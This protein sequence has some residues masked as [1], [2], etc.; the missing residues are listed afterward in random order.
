MTAPVLALEDASFAFG[1]L[2]ILDEESV[3]VERGELVALVGPNGSGKTTV[4]ELLAGLRDPDSGTVRRPA[5]AA[6]STAYLPQSPGFRSGFTVRETLSFYAGLVG[7]GV[8]ADAVLDRVGLGDAADRRVEA[9]SGGMTRLLGL[10][11][12]LVGD[13]PVVVLDEPTSGLDPDVSDS[14]FDATAALATDDRAVVVSSHDLAAVEARA[15]RV[16]LV[17]DGAIAFD[18][19]PEDLLAETGAGTLR[20]AFS[21]AVAGRE[22]DA[23][24][25]AP[26]GGDAQ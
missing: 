2:T 16:V 3:A 11:Q 17:A 7:G 10:A 22:L 24:A 20:A 12:A 9:L 5:N 25:A 8:D 1:D 13:P 6:R 19:P 4:L 23:T 18:G 15:D 26:S 21:R 14:V